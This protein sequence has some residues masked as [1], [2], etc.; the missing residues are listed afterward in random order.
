[1]NRAVVKEGFARDS[2][3]GAVDE[4]L[5]QHDSSF[6]PDVRKTETLA[7]HLSEM[8][9]DV[10]KCASHVNFSC[11]RTFEHQ[12]DPLLRALPALIE[13]AGVP[14]SLATSNPSSHFSACS[15]IDD[16]LLRNKI[17]AALR[18]RGSPSI[19]SATVSVTSRSELS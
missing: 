12:S 7:T 9:G 11:V 4:K 14:M 15:R 16:S 5:R 18:L 8:L 13:P 6:Q 19:A 2:V 1:M 3:Q 17:S 10:P